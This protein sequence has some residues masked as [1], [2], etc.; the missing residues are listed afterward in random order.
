MPLISALGSQRQVD[1]CEIKAWSAERVPGQPGLFHREAL[2]QG[3]KGRNEG[4]KERKKGDIELVNL[5]SL[6]YLPLV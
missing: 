4:E 5:K 1:F 3:K 2:S 6:T